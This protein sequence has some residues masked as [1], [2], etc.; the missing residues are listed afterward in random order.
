MPDK[1][2]D[3]WRNVTAYEAKQR[4]AVA[5]AIGMHLK[6]KFAGVVSEPLPESMTEL[7]TKIKRRR[8]DS[9]AVGGH[10]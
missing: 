10:D 8:G 9:N 6:F 2:P 5:K 3:R 7:M 4:S 1:A